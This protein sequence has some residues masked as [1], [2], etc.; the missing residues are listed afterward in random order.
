MH[1]YDTV[2]TRA[3]RYVQGSGC[4][5]VGVAGL[6]QSG[7][8]GSLSKNYGTAA[9]CLL[10]AEIVTADGTVR[11]ANA[12]SNPEL[13]WG[14]KGGG[15]GSLGVITRLTLKTHELPDWFGGVSMTIGAATDSAF[16]RLIGGFIDLYGSRLF[17]P[18]WGERVE[19]RCNNTLRIAMVSQA[20]DK[21]QAEDVWQP[22][23][24]WV[25]ASSRE[26]AVI[27]EPTIGS[28]PARHW[29]DAEFRRRYRPAIARPDNT[30]GTLRD[31]MWW[32]SDGGQPG[33]F[34]HGYESA[35]LPASLLAQ[36][37]RLAD[38]LFATS[39]HWT[40]ALHFNKGLAGGL[41]AA[42]TAARDT[43]T[44]PEMIDGFALAIIA[45]GGP[46]AYL[47]APDL[48]VARRNARAIAAAMA[49]LR[50]AI[51][52]TGSYVS[53]SSFFQADWQR[54]YW[55]SNYPRLRA[56]KAKYDPD[57]LF[58]VHHGVGTEDWSDNGFTRLFAR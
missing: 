30:P 2:T 20:L 17:N 49:T 3:G 23:L 24:D 10:E 13:F 46:S 51:P 40:V 57:G 39:R 52:V 43:A 56:V 6:V 14:I 44:N 53:E 19:F 21:Q 5:T 55:G 31:D 37:E 47:A 42:A 12:C 33:S 7:G 32:T 54:A 15:G 34:L 38:A 50:K 26:L 35:W 45:G 36:P 48:A 1:V 58:Y 29:W 41:V 11:I 27:G 28:M 22:F 18:Y 16:R 25:G 9:G 8:F 4:A